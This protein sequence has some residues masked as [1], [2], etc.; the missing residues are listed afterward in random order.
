MRRLRILADDLTGALDCAAAFGAGVPVRLGRP[1]GAQPGAIDIVATA[2]R[3]LPAR[4]LDAHLAPALAWLRGADVAFKKID[5]LLRGNTFA[6]IDRL[7]RQTPFSALGVV[8]AFPAQQ[9]LTLHGQQRWRGPDGSWAVAGDLRA[10]LQALGWR[11][12][13]GPEPPALDGGPLAWVP[14][15]HSDSDLDRAARHALQAG[16]SWL[17]CASAGLAHALARHGLRP[18]PL[19]EALSDPAASADDKGAATSGQ[20]LLVSASH[21][22]VT[23][24]QWQVLQH[25][26][27]LRCLHWDTA[28]EPPRL[29]Q[30]T[31]GPTLLDLSPQRTLPAAEASALLQA[32]VLTLTRIAPRPR[33]LVVV[34]GD[35]LLALCRALGASGLCSAQAPA[36]AGWGCAR[37]L[38]GRWPDLLCHTRSGAFGGPQDL[39]E[40]LRSV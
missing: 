36:R 24:A 30:D 38:G 13:T 22:P 25:T 20:A 6:E 17:W 9:R 28:T 31:P 16:P 37:L 23:R 2:T 5:S 12:D 26:P 4:D 21:H 14:D 34:G 19:S 32:Q 11:V 18:D 3:D 15:V 39:L 7:A 29:Q 27:G 8:P 10:K 33:V 35:T 40:M 1:G